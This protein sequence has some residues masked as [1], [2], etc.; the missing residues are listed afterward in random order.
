MSTRDK[1]REDI[2]YALYCCSC[3]TME[4]MTKT[5]KGF[6]CDPNKE[7]HFRRT[8]CGEEFEFT[9]EF[10]KELEGLGWGLRE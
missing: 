5:Y 7:D 10:L 8:G 6:K 3:N 1:L 4:R 2:N 9:E